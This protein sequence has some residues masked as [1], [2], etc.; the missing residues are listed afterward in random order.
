MSNQVKHSTIN[1]TEIEAAAAVAVK[2][3]LEA[4]GQAGIDLTDEQLNSVSGGAS[5]YLKDP[6]IY[7]ILVDPNWGWKFGGVDAQVNPAQLGGIK[8]RFG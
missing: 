1:A 7:G 6:F 2:R 3:A 8:T 4:R 5:Y